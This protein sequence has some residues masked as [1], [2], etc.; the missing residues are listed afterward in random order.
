MGRGRLLPRETFI[1][2]RGILERH[3][4]PPDP[5]CLVTWDVRT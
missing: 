4:V 3:R 2:L 5:D 1:D